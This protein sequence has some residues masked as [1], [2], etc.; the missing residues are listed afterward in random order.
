[1]R[2]QLII[3]IIIYFKEI[4]GGLWG[5]RMDSG[6][7]DTLSTLMKT[8]IHKVGTAHYLSLYIILSHLQYLGLLQA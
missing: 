6:Y 7:R 4:L 1:M 3:I 2:M 8:L 5:A